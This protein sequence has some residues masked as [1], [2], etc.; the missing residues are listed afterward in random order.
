MMM[1]GPIPSGCGEGVGSLSGGNVL[2]AGLKKLELHLPNPAVFVEWME[3]SPYPRSTITS[4]FIITHNELAPS[5]S[6]LHHNHRR[7][8]KAPSRGVAIVCCSAAH[9]CMPECMQTLP[10]S[11]NNELYLSTM[12]MRWWRAHCRPEMSNRWPGSQ[13]V[14]R[15]VFWFGPRPL[16]PKFIR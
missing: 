15:E 9:A 4:P 7:Y 10:I 14:T 5:F 11:Q 2:C 12:A 16:E 3:V 1:I 13:T 8:G 6:W